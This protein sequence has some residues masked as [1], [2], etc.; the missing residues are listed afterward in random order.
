MFTGEAVLRFTALD[1]I[2]PSAA[3]AREGQLVVRARDLRFDRAAPLAT[4]GDISV[5]C[6][7]ESLK[8]RAA[9]AALASKLHFQAYA[10]FSGDGPLALDAELAAARMR[11]SRRDGR[12]LVD[13]PVRVALALAD[14]SLDLDY[15]EKSQG[16][17]HVALEVGP[18]LASVSAAKRQDALE[19]DMTAKAPRLGSLV[20][21]LMPAEAAPR[22]AWD[23]MAFVL[24]SKGRVERLTA[25]QPKI[26]QRTEIRVTGI[27]VDTLATRAVALECESSG[28]TRRHGLRADLRAEGLTVG[29]AALGDDHLTLLASL[30]RSFPSLHIK[31]SNEGLANADLTANVAFDRVRHAVSYDLVGHLSS[32]TPLLPLLAKA[33]KYAGIELSEP[34]FSLVSK[35]YVVGVVSDVDKRGAVGMAPNPLRT[36]GGKGDME[37]S[38][39][40]IRWSEGDRAFKLPAATW[41]ASLQSEGERRAIESDLK[42]DGFDLGMGRKWIKVSGFKGHT[43]A[44]FTGSLETGTIELS[45]RASIRAIKQNYARMYPIGDV[46]VTMRARRNTEGLIRLLELRLENP[47][48][49]TSLAVNGG[50]DL[51]GEQ[52]RIAARI[53]LQQDLAR[54]STRKEQFVGLG[55]TS[56]DLTV[57][58]PDLR[59]FHTKA[60][61]R[62][63]EA[64]VYLPGFHVALDSIDGEL[65]M[66][67]DVAVGRNGVEF[68]H[69]IQV[70]P[71]TML[72]FSDQHPLLKRQSFLSIGSVTTPFFSFAPFAANIEVEQNIVSLSQL[73]MGLRGG[74][75]TGNGLF[76]WKGAKSKVHADIRMSGVQSS[77]GEPFDG[78]AA[79]VVDLSDRSIEGKADILRIGRRHLLDL[80]DLEDPRRADASMNRIRSALGMGYPKRVNIAFKH[81]FASAGVSFGGLAQLMSVGDV[82]GIAIGPLMERALQSFKL[83]EQP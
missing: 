81:G 28:T 74:R 15:P 38:A 46:T 48:G 31:L 3:G 44:T 42:I 67:C 30:D 53:Q 39:S 19:Y 77:Y 61:L 18:L 5:E 49:G 60:L 54:A 70:N 45:Q 37:L 22:V 6:D 83:E 64:K 80:I 8:G 24:T 52:R 10:Q 25:P 55:K 41:R 16:T 63:E 34:E 29:D 27:N 36:A 21:P 82:R 50:F 17:A 14:V 59:V 51:G 76:E 2:G 79:L 71:Y 62:L 47:S 23:K 40:H 12:A 33:S 4:R 58:S 72:R 9:I 78:N 65:P 75:V 57:Q 11:A 7:I 26:H 32:L 56:L 69:S 43:S 35:G 20:P 73:E 68:L 13:T 66:L 1:A